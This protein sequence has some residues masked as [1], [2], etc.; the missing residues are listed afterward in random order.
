MNV[1]IEGPDG[2]GKSTLA[3]YVARHL[4]KHLQQG[5]GPPK[6]PG[7]VERRLTTYLHMT[8]TVFDRHPA[9]SQVIYGQLR[10]ETMSPE[11]ASLVLDFY[12]ADNLIIYC[13][14]VDA[15]RHVVKE[16]EDPAHVEVLTRRYQDLVG[17]Y[18]DWALRHA[19]LVYRIGESMDAIVDICRSVS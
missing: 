15:G 12:H 10:D 5:S 13:R 16:G 11:F 6:A 2:G 14:S 17:L 1:V 7:E 18:D 9:V 8:D 4:G 3:E 19:H